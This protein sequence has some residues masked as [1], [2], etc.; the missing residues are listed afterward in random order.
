[1]RTACASFFLIAVTALAADP[2]DAELRDKVLK[3]NKEITNQDSANAKLKELNKDKAGTPKLVKAAAQAL[4]E[5]K[6][7]EKPFRFYPAMVLAKAA[8]NA[9]EYEPAEAFY[10]FCADNAINDLKTPKLIKLA[11]I[12]QIDYYLARKQYVKA[13]DACKRAEQL[14]EDDENLADLWALAF[15]KQLRA[16]AR[17]GEADAALDQINNAIKKSRRNESQM[18]QLTSIKATVEHD[19]GKLEDALST[20]KDLLKMVDDGSAF[21]DEGKKEIGDGLRYTMSGLF[22]EMG[23]VEEATNELDKLVKEY[24]DNATYKNDLGFTLAD[25]DL[26]LDKA[27]RL[28]RDAVDMDLKARKKLADEGKIDP[29]LAKKANPAYIDSLG[30]VLF[31]KKKYEEALKNLIE[32]ASSGDDESDHIEIWDHVGDC[33]LAMDRKKEALESFQK[34]LKMED[35]TKKDAERRR[36]VTEKINKL[37]K[38]MK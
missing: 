32:S 3:F 21:T 29:E 24:P 23:K 38:E 18:V 26:N 34:A 12:S 13:I 33:Y 20:Y 8:Q 4:R 35:N 11:C 16:M 5:A 17:N 27:E 19:A 37:K 31:K 30:W 2:T 22:L 10:K 9:K 6:S 25:N 15:E 28:I 14:A 7:G 1:M 36:K